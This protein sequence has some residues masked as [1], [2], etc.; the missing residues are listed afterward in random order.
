MH[1]CHPNTAYA[2]MC[3]LLNQNNVQIITCSSPKSILDVKFV[4]AN[5]H[6]ATR[7]AFKIRSRGY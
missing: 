3:S 6:E 2:Q 5:K 4:F 7:D 1:N